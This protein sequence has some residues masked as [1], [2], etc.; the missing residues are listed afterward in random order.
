M[1]LSS[2]RPSVCRLSVTLVRPTQPVEI[3]SNVSSPLV[4][5]PSELTFTENFTEIVQGE[6]SVWGV[7]HNRRGHS[8]FGPIEGYISETVQI[9]GKI[10]L[11]T[12]R[13]SHTS[14][15]MVPKSVTL[16]DLERRYFT[17]LVYDVVVKQLSRFQNLL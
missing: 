5:W 1:C 17:E 7:E 16:N 15:R 14:F 12:N 10:V 2:Y 8:D 6:P 11:I 3:F 9:G 4:P 13:K